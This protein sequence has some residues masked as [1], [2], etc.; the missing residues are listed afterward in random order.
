MCTQLY[1]CSWQYI[2][3]FLLQVLICV[4]IDLVDSLNSCVWNNISNLC[5]VACGIL[6]LLIFMITGDLHVK[7]HVKPHVKC[8]WKY[9][10][11]SSMWNSRFFAIQWGLNACESPCE[12]P[13]EVYVKICVNLHVSS[14]WNSFAIQWGFTCESLCETSCEVYVKIYVKGLTSFHT[15]FTYISLC[16]I[17]HACEISVWNSCEKC[18]KNVW[19]EC[20][21]WTI[22][23]RFFTWCFTHILLVVFTYKIVSALLL[24]VLTS[25]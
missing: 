9:V 14:M 5:E 17:S 11:I 23:T 7:A 1:A 8:M 25:Q 13:F 2:R 10:W 24:G 21:N 3:Q 19:K 4:W 16:K 12:T 6:L 18:V 15:L 22:F 20:E